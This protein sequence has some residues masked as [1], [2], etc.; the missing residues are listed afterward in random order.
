MP[1]QDK[2]ARRK[3]HREYLRRRYSEDAEYRKRHREVVAKTRE[4]AKLAIK[5]VVAQFR[6]SGCSLCDER[7]ACCLTAHHRDRSEKE[8]DLGNYLATGVSPA[9]FLAELSKCVCVCFN[10][11]AKIH[12]GLLGAP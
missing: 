4:R 5:Q 9:R 10:C 11:H 8:F 6:A 12:A 3:Y 1:L 2:E 7:A